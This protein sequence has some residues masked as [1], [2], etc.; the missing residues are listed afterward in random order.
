VAIIS[1]H[2]TKLLKNRAIRLSG[3]T[4]KCQFA[5]APTSSLYAK[6][7]PPVNAQFGSG[8]LTQGNKKRELIPHPADYERA[9]RPVF[10]RA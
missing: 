4:Q 1:K 10:R 7:A 5:P 9:V 2:T 3:H 8:D 6:T